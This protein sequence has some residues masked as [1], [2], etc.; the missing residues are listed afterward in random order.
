MGSDFERI[1]ELKQLA[2]AAYNEDRAAATVELLKCYLEHFPDD[3]W[4]WFIYGDSLRILGRKGAAVVA[5]ANAEK[6]CSPERKWT[7]QGRLGLLFHDA[8]DFSAAERWYARA[9]EADEAQQAS[10]IWIFRGANFAKQELLDEAK[11]C[12]LKAISVNQNDEEAY[13]NLGMV[14][15]AQGS[16][17]EAINA[18]QTALAICPKYP[19]AEA[20]LKSLDG[21]IE[22]VNRKIH[23]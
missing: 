10:W 8:G 18:A 23:E 9:L 4:A 19:D 6:T 17:E 7:V 15:R 16:Y 1:E 11:E 13:L 2:K 21:A 14:S 20:L 3:D 12:H 5:L 22:A